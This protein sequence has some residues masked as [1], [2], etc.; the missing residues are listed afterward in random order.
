MRGEASHCIVIIS[1]N[2]RSL[3]LRPVFYDHFL[4]NFSAL[5]GIRKYNKKA[6]AGVISPAIVCRQRLNKKR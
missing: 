2:K 3:F 5:V 1:T 6:I 4:V